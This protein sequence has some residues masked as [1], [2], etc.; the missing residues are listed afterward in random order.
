MNYWLSPLYENS[1]Q[2]SHLV[3]QRT[4]CDIFSRI[5]ITVYKLESP[6]GFFYHA[7]SQWNARNTATQSTRHSN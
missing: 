7:I 1:L 3:T 4:Q 2:N 6:F 5:L